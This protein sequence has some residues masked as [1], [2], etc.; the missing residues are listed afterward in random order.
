MGKSFLRTVAF[1]MRAI[2]LLS[3]SALC[4]TVAEENSSLTSPLFSLV[5]PIIPWTLPCVNVTISFGETSVP[6]ILEVYAGRIRTAGAAGD[7]GGLR[8]VAADATA[9]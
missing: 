7:T 1:R 8:N 6:A 3:S 2:W 9:A 4:F 5:A